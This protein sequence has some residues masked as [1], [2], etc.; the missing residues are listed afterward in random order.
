[1]HESVVYFL[2]LAHGGFRLQLSQIII[3][4]N[5]VI[6]RP[7]YPKRCPYR[8]QNYQTPV[9][10]CVTTYDEIWKQLLQYKTGECLVT[11][12]DV[13]GMD[14]GWEG[15]EVGG[16]L[17]TLSNVKVCRWNTEEYWKRKFPHCNI[18]ANYVW[19]F[20]QFTSQMIKKKA[21]L[22]LNE[23]RLF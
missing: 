10:L 22:T 21:F 9:L 6:N 2:K 20:V 5:H 14:R 23:F 18:C 11:P 7:T 19:H 13:Q 4:N 3:T 16:Y 12:S 1:M 8:K 17:T 15:G